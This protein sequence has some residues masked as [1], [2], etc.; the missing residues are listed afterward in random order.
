LE[1]YDKFPLTF[2]N[3]SLDGHGCMA[4]PKVSIQA[5]FGLDLKEIEKRG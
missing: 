2:Q 3:V 1:K 5:P 4:K